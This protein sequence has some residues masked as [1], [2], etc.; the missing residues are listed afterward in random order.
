[1]AGTQEG[2]VE[3]GSSQGIAQNNV[4]KLCKGLLTKI[5]LT[6]SRV[7]LKRMLMFETAC[8]ITGH[9][10]VIKARRSGSKQW[11]SSQKSAPKS[12]DR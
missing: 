2:P 11:H 10:C 1:M 7:I 8:K 3:S 9:Q 5:K 4:D 12:V 6:L